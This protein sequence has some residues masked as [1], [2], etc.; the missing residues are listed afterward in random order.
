MPDFDPKALIE[1]TIMKEPTTHQPLP[2]GYDL[3][4]PTSLAMSV[5]RK[6]LRRETEEAEAAQK[7]ENIAQK[8]TPIEAAT[9]MLDSIGTSP[10]PPPP[11]D[12]EG[13]I[14]SNELK[15]SVDQAPKAPKP[16]GPVKPAEVKKPKV[17]GATVTE[18]YNPNKPFEEP[19]YKETYAE[20]KEGKYVPPPAPSYGDVKK[21]DV[22]L[23]KAYSANPTPQNLKPLMT[24]MQPLMH[25]EVNRWKAAAPQ[26]ALHRQAQSLT[27]HAIKTYDPTKGAALGTHV[28]NR[29]KKLSRTAYQHQDLVRLPENKK[30]RSQ[31]LYNAQSELQGE[32]GRDPTND[33]LADRLAWSP[34][35][36][37]DVQRSM[38]G[39]YVESQ[40]IGGEMFSDVYGRD[41]ADP[42]LDYVYYDLDPTDKQIF[43]HL[44]GYSGKPIMTMQQVGQKLGLTDSQVRTRKKRIE[45]KIREAAG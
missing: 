39:E 27:L 4:T 30:L 24:A 23:W 8:S 40:D 6:A 36:V 9:E 26:P 45:K 18:A 38:V 20:A 2:G 25:S 34:K 42:V 15:I 37:S 7:A 16:P 12:A 31:A 5:L 32:L 10:T 11:D 14:E 43:E 33:E 21:K 35:R 44:T 22:E 29:L 19:K 13:F 3:R 1:R 41:A 28:M 17:E